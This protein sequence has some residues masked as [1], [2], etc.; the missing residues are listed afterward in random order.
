[1]ANVM[2]GP[3]GHP[4]HYPDLPN[5]YHPN[6][7]FQELENLLADR[8]VLTFYDDDHI[9]VNDMRHMETYGFTMVQSHLDQGDDPANSFIAIRFHVH[10]LRVLLNPDSTVAERIHARCSFAGTVS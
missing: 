7:I 1:M 3:N 8:I 9:V 2:L 4:L 6:E 5:P 10:P